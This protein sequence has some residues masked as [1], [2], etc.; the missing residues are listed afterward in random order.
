MR[1]KIFFILA[2]LTGIA[3]FAAVAYRVVY[4]VDVLV[5]GGLVAMVVFVTLALIADE[6]IGWYCESCGESWKDS[7][8]KIERNCYYGDDRDVWRCPKCKQAHTC[9]F[10][11]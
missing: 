2:A 10:T 11:E 3:T 5:F 4:R 9:P 7:E 8:V 6:S 1:R